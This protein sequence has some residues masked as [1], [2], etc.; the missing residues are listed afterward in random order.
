MRNA[1]GRRFEVQAIL[2]FLLSWQLK[3][4]ALMGFF[5]FEKVD[6]ERLYLT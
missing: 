5:N 3:R 4:V 1:L 6:L 2:S